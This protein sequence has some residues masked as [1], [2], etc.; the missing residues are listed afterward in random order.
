MLKRLALLLLLLGLAACGG[1]IDHGSSM[2]PSAAAVN[3]TLNAS[4]FGFAPAQIEV[5]AGQTIK[6]TLQNIGTQ[7][8]DILSTKKH[9]GARR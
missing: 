7:D 9:E 2:A 1:A 5:A 6:V 8:H 4:D 3:V